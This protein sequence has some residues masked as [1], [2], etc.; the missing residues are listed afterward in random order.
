MAARLP[1]DQQVAQAGSHQ[2]TASNRALALSLLDLEV[3]QIALVA[4]VEFDGAEDRTVVGVT[5]RPGLRNAVDVQIENE[6]DR[7]RLTI[8]LSCHEFS[9]ENSANGSSL[10]DTGFNISIRFLEFRHIRDFDRFADGATVPLEIYPDDPP[11]LPELPP[12]FQR[13]LLSPLIHPEIRSL[14]EAER[15]A[16][17]WE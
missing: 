5:R 15:G 4:C 16:T 11:T 8:A 6:V 12:G 1:W 13:K 2:A 7:R 3:E 9:E 10:T 14:S 17:S